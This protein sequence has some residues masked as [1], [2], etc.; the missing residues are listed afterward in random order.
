MVTIQ[1]LVRHGAR[2]RSAIQHSGPIVTGI[3]GQP[4]TMA[5]C[6]FTMIAKA[7]PPRV[8]EMGGKRPATEI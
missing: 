1:G 5:T 4:S 2:R 3:V 8:I 7:T 6:Q